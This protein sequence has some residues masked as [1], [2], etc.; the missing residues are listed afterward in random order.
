MRRI[1]IF[2]AVILF[3]GGG[4]MAISQYFKKHDDL[5]KKSA[6]HKLDAREL[7]LAFAGDEQR[8]NELYLNKVIE[9]TGTVKKLESSNGKNTQVLLSADDPMFGVICDLAPGEPADQVKPGDL[10]TLRG[11]CS[12]YLMDV[13]LNRC[14]IIK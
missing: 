7:F 8:A 12:G 13:A 2:A 4:A 6:D 10:I 14:V 1:L 9:V 5:A 11:T 3:L